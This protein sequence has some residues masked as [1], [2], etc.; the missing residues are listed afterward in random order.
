MPSQVVAPADLLRAARLRARN[1]GIFSACLLA[2]VAL[3][4]PQTAT[5][6]RTNDWTTGAYGHALRIL[7]VDLV[8]AG[9]ILRN[10]IVLIEAWIALRLDWSIAIPAAEDERL[11]LLTGWLGEYWRRRDH[12]AG[13][14]GLAG[15]VVVLIVA[16]NFAPPG[17]QSM[18]VFC[19]TL[20]GA[21]AGACLSVA[22]SDLWTVA[23]HG[24]NYV[25]ALTAVI[26]LDLIL[27]GRQPPRSH[28]GVQAL[29]ACL[30]A[31]LIFWLAPGYSLIDSD[32]MY[33]RSEMEDAV[34]IWRYDEI[35]GF[36][37]YRHSPAKGPNC[38]AYELHFRSGEVVPLFELDVNCRQQ[39]KAFQW[40]QA[41]R[42]N[43]ALERTPEFVIPTAQRP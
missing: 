13:F 3:T 28:S 10:L 30:S 26:S 27:I 23:F 31:F 22:L 8:A 41:R 21:L 34:K 4:L 6:L 33:L 43:P 1:A 14:G 40:I 15:L 5:A 38:W 32:A 19:L 9:A 24:A 11:P 12:A 16:R 36:E 25:K 18:L 20:A 7:M 2:F 29:G 42:S 35:I 17:V 39:E 37:R